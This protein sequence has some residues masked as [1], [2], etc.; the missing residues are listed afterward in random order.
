MTNDKK[1]YIYNRDRFRS[2]LGLLLVALVIIFI[3][4]VAISYAGTHR[5]EPGYYATGSNGALVALTPM[6]GK[7]QNKKE[8]FKW[9]GVEK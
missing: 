1:G 7:E 2:E 6:P 4:I 8:F 9:L 3:L 5:G